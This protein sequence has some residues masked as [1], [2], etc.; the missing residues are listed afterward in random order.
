MKQGEEIRKVQKIK[1]GNGEEKNGKDR[2]KEG[3]EL[4]SEQ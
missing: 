2:C 1:E 4:K 3:D